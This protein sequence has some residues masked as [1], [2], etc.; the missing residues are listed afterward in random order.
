MKDMSNYVDV[1]FVI[2]IMVLFVL[3]DITIYSIF[4]ICCA[5]IIGI[6]QYF[7]LIKSE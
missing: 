7:K 3:S 6:T 2:I 4:S 1:L 5:V